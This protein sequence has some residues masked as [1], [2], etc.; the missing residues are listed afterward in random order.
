[1]WF[2]VDESS[3]RVIQYVQEVVTHFIYYASYIEWGTTSWTH[4]NLT[5]WLESVLLYPVISGIKAEDKRGGGGKGNWGTMD[6]EMKG[7]V[8]VIAF[9]LQVMLNNLFC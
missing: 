8:S 3:R 9:Y 6:D 7:K 2:F 4:S 1:M 5:K